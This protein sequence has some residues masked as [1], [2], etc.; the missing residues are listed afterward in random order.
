MALVQA[1]Q[2]DYSVIAIGSNDATAAAINLVL[3]NT[4]IPA[5]FSSM[6]AQRVTSTMAALAAADPSHHLHQIVANIPDIIETPALQS[7]IAFYGVSQQDVNALRQ[8]IIDANT[9]I[10]AAARQDGIPVLDLFKLIDDVGSQPL[11][12][13]GVTTAVADLYPYD[14]FH[15]SALHSRADGRYVHRRRRP[16]IRRHARSAE[17][18]A[19]RIQRG[20]LTHDNRT[21][22]LRRLAVCDRAGTVRPNHRRI[23][24]V[25]SL[26]IGCDEVDEAASA[27]YLRRRLMMPGP[28]QA[29]RG[30][31]VRE[32][33]TG[34]TA[35]R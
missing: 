2:L 30:H 25:S 4:P 21:D 31:R 19:N 11:T 35:N 33:R 32:R 14:G 15:P 28:A 8:A 22:V 3:N 13:A 16:R 12:L 18:S 20:P 29:A 27:G 6:V 17:R 34:R 26:R 23:E 24:P 10:E 1:Q 5:D 9:Q 7:A